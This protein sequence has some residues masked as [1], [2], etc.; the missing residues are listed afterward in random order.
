[1]GLNS[2]GSLTS[3]MAYPTRDSEGVGDPQGRAKIGWI[4]LYKLCIF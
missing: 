4:D 3:I 2:M 1:M